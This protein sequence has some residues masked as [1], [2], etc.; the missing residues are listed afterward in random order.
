MNDT[1]SMNVSRQTVSWRL[2]EIERSLQKK[3]IL[4]KKNRSE[5][6]N[7]HAI[8]SYG[9]LFFSDESKYNFFCNDGKNFVRRHESEKLNV[10]CTKKTVKFGDGSVIAFLF[11]SQGISPLVCLFVNGQVYKNL[12][13]G[14]VEPNVVNSGVPKPIFMQ[15]NAPVTKELL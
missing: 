15:N 10:M 3:T 14:I 9:K 8:W 11:S 2:Q 5:F 12:L 7:K 1:I 13:E 4:S 6:A